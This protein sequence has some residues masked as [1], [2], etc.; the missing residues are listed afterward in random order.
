MTKRRGFTL[1]E[2]MVVI[3]II[4][5][6]VGLLLPAVQKVREGARRTACQS[7][8][9]QIGI[10]MHLYAEDYDGRFPCWT[11]TGYGVGNVLPDAS[12]Q[13]LWLLYNGKYTDNVKIFS[14][15]SKASQYANIRNVTDV[16]SI[17]SLDPADTS[18]SYD[19]RHTSSHAGPTIVAGDKRDSGS[20]GTNHGG[21]VANFL[22]ID[23][24]VT[25]M[26]KAR[27]GT[28]LAY[29]N[30]EDTDIWAVG[31]AAMVHDSCLVNTE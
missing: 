1:I 18:Y 25:K 27:T 6:L 9:R 21:E 5:I 30:T 4:G 13:A 8:L 19:P 20:V 14:C 17:A 23:G 2:L 24:S 29:S 11:T 28:A 10:A 12:V 22:A 3:A 31:N 16:G 15:A 7:N 26:Q